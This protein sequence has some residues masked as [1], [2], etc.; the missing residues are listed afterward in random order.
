MAARRTVTARGRRG[1]VRWG[2]Y[3]VF[4]PLLRLSSYDG[5]AK[6]STPNH[7]RRLLPLTIAVSVSAGVL[8]RADDLVLSRFSDYLDSLRVQLGIPGMAVTL[9]RLTDPNWERAYGMQDQEQLIAARPDTPFEMDGTTQ[10]LSAVIVMQ[11]VEE[12]R[13]SLDAPLQQFSPNASEPNATVRQLLSHTSLVSGALTFSYNPSRLETLAA[14]VP[15]CTGSSFREAVYHRL[16]DRLAMVDSIPGADVLSLTPPADGTPLA[17]GITAETLTRFKAV[18]DRLAKPY[19]VD[20]RGRSSPSQYTAVS[21]TP[22]SGLIST[23]RDM[24]KFDAAL[25]HGDLVRPE[26]L[27]VAWTPPLDRNGQRLPHGLGWFVQSYN[28][29][30]VVW[31]FGVS[32]NAS[33]S[34]VIMVP[35][36]GL[37]LLLAANSSGLAKSFSLGSGDVMVSPFARLFLSIYVR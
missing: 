33:S 15:T 12:G 35:G 7:M 26:T 1:T 17:D 8:L 13:I 32:D 2:G 5:S 31:Q 18:F 36:R 37:T 19:A 16:L 10:L 24:A 27:A 11:C 14:V 34:M 4:D 25:R 3:D 20:S 30:R 9:I 6:G 21:L 28:G 22:A 29:E 23:V